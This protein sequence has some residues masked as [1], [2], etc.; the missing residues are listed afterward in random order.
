MQHKHPWI[1]NQS[2]IQSSRGYNY[3]ISNGLTTYLHNNGLP[4]PLACQVPNTDTIAWYKTKE[5]AEEAIKLYLQ[6]HLSEEEKQQDI[7]IHN[8]T[9]HDNLSGIVYDP[10]QREYYNKTTDI[11][12]SDD[13]IEYHKLRPYDKITTPLPKYTPRDYF[14]NPAYAPE[15][16]NWCAAKSPIFYLHRN[17]HNGNDT[18]PPTYS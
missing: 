8:N 3:Y 6:K 13:D 16:H 17:K 15:G 7:P 18:N 4:Y 10:Q 5:D 11:F 12:L 2:N 14:T 9:M 1:I